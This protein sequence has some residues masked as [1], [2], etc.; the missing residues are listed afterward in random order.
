MEH[1]FL[2]NGVITLTPCGTLIKIYNNKFVRSELCTMHDLYLVHVL[3]INAKIK[4]F[5]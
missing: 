3:F 5:M 4:L 2:N 1:G